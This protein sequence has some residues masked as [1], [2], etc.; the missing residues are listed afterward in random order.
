MFFTTGL[1]A[2]G[3][4]L[5]MNPASRMRGMPFVEVSDFQKS[6]GPGRCASRQC[7]A[8]QPLER[9][10]NSA[11][12]DST[13]NQ[14]A[15]DRAAQWKLGPGRTQPGATAQSEEMLFTFEF[16]AYPR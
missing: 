6:G 7:L 5:V 3:T 9:N 10:G 14:D 1:T 2:V 11:S 4:G 12:S 8:G 15:L 16:L 13:L